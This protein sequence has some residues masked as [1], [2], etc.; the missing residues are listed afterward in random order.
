MTIRRALT[1]LLAATLP[2]AAAATEFPIPGKPI[3]I[4]VGFPAGGGTDLQARQVAQQLTTVLGGAPVIIENKPGAGTMLAAMEVAKATPDGHTPASH[5]RVRHDRVDTT[6]VVTLRHAGRLHH[7]GLGRTHA[8][9]HVLLLVHDLN[10]R[11][12]NATTGE[13]LRE[14]TLNPDKDYQPTARPP[15]PQQRE[16]RT[17]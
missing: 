10:I 2:L 14:L 11:V 4:L 12:I 16:T 1:A 7:I 6:G 8:R 3:R 13:L 17:Q 9:T 15:G 5:E